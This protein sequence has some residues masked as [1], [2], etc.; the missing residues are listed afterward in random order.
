MCG[1]GCDGRSAVTILL[2][3]AALP[4]GLA[5]QVKVDPEILAGLEARAIGP[6]TMSG[7]I[8]AL[9]AIPGPPATIYVGAAGGGVWKSS[10][11]GV[12][13][14]SVFDDHVQSI[15]AIAID[16]SNPQTVWVGTGESWVRNSVSVGDGVYKTT[17]GGDRWTRVGLTDTERI[18]RIV[19]HPRHGDTVFVCAAGHLW[20]GNDERGIFKTTDG[21][22]T[23][24]RVL[25]VNRDT[26]CS[27]LALDPQ[28]P[29]LL[30]AGMWQFRRR[31]DFFTSG[32]PGS[33]L[34]KSTDGGE[35]WRPLT[36]GLP[37]GEKGRIAVAVAPSRTSVLYAIVEARR[38][39]LFRS[40]DLGESWTEVNAS[41]TAQG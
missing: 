13:F 20:D 11:G 1:N 6:A 7:R 28:D 18:A 8:A 38:T 12:T 21:G 29:R 37:E 3:L 23:W 34:F 14:Q 25:F 24:K 36:R 16:P 27:D 17:D 4:A 31:P 30:Y 15:G 19:V 10:D 26:G 41:N 40:D 22:K 5:A 35:T 33:G 9:D 39:A 2:F 32:G